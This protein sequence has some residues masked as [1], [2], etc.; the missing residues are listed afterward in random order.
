ML[1]SV[2]ILFVAGYVTVETIFPKRGEFDSL[3]RFALSVGLSIAIAMFVGLKA[4]TAN[5]FTD[6][7]YSTIADLIRQ[8]H[9]NYCG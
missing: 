7:Y 2:F 6:T 5:V 1:E 9:S 8:S 3:E 4:L